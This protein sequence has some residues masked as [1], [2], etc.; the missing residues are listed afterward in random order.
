V[1][2]ASFAG[3]QG[4]RSEAYWDW[5]F[6]RNPHG[7]GH[8]W[9][10]EDEGRVAACYIWNPV[11]MRAG[12]A[13]LSATQ[14][15]DAAVHPDFQ[16]QSLFTRLARMAVEQTGELG[17]DLVYAFPT[18]AAWRGQTRVGFVTQYAVPVIQRPLLPV[19]RKPRAAGLELAPVT[20]FDDEFVPLSRDGRDGLLTVQRDPSYLQWRYL[21][22]PTYR[23]D[24]AQCRR[25][26][27]VVGYSVVRVSGP[28]AWVID[29]QVLPGER[30]A[31]GLLAAHAVE[32]M[33]KQGARVGLSFRRPG[34]PEDDAL[35]ACGFSSV[36]RRVKQR[37]KR[38]PYV[39][40]F[41][42]Y[43]PR[44]L[45]PPSPAARLAWS[46]VPSDADWS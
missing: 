11:L 46:I 43:A 32:H 30:A 18:V 28:R 39:S 34:G 42:A 37:V 20:A 9:L 5:K 23:Y 31:A 24:V 12:S 3:W 7:R 40:Q 1:L 6:E 21:E 36:Y 4:E 8:V 19:L 25:D 35:R 27:R 38:P 16:G 15:V 13:T 33:R 10:A 45:V 2:R 29:L 26:G 22:H 17:L 44:E 14:S 41:I